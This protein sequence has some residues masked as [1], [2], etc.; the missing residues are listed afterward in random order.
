MFGFLRRKRPSPAEPTPSSDDSASS[1]TAAATAQAAPAGLG[2]PTQSLYPPEMLYPA[3]VLP[4]VEPEPEPEPS[5]ARAPAESPPSEVPEVATP[6]PEIDVASAA[7]ATPADATRVDEPSHE[8]A[9]QPAP[10]P[11]YGS[12][13]T[14]DVLARPEAIV[15][16]SGDAI[17][18]LPEAER[19]RWVK[20]LRE[21]M[22]RTRGN[23]AGLFSNVQVDDALFDE[24]ESALIASDAG[25][26]TS[27][28]L[29]QR[30][31]ERVRR[32]RLVDAEQVRLA[33]RALL[34]DLL[35]PLEKPMDIDAAEPL[36]MMIAGVNG[37]GK[38]TSIGKLAHHLQREGKS[39]L[40]AAGDTFR[41]AAREQLA[42]WGSRNRVDVIAQQG[43]DPAAVAFDA[44]HAGRARRTGIV[45]I[46]TAGRLPTQT[47]LME[48]LRKIRR[49]VAK[50]MENA[51]HETLL[52]LDGNTG[53]NML[54][55][56]KAFDEAVPLSGL[57][58]T[59]LDGTAKGG[60]LAALAFTRRERPIPVY[61]IGVGE[62]IDDL[63]AFSAEEFAGALLD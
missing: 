21:G 44:V 62:K 36:V 1:G 4:R 9:A 25:V 61:F 38:T 18:T 8:A 63:Q 60:A 41:A 28:W 57:I 13:Y 15:L 6:E 42:E 59:K 12:L 52:V 58:V 49:V 46:D 47:H 51:P 54:A 24:L 33:L 14:A 22:S 30:L 56:V 53:Q 55:Q 3:E 27:Q 7:A 50:A 48:E 32:E 29:M 37:A 40:L 31:Q 19:N 5:Q 26:A 16:P 45:I 11:F 23:L 34:V 35:M 39:I 17:I 10:A 43:G 2:L 20:R